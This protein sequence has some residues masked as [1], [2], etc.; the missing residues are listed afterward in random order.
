MLRVEGSTARLT[1]TEPEALQPKRVVV[2]NVKA[3]IGKTAESAMPA[4]TNPS[5]GERE[6]RS[7]LVS[8][9]CALGRTLQEN[10]LF[11]APPLSRHHLSFLRL[12]PEVAAARKLKRHQNQNPSEVANPSQS[13]RLQPWQRYILFLRFFMAERYFQCFAAAVWFWASCIWSWQVQTWLHSTSG[14]KGRGWICYHCVWCQR[15]WVMW[16]ILEW[17][18]QPS[19]EAE[20]NDHGSCKGWRESITSKQWI[21]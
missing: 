13:F 19:T 4:S 5:L 7:K 9:E 10:V 2:E 21:R 17:H 14:Q 12:L 18:G 11:L 3:A 15:H 1:F 8:T 16:K 20:K 6:L